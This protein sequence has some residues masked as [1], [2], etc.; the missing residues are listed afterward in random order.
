MSGSDI[1]LHEAAAALMRQTVQGMGNDIDVRLRGHRLSS[2][3]SSPM[4]LRCLL[5]NLHRDAVRTPV[6]RLLTH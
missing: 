1:V 6:T 3:R 4:R 5:Q 2:P